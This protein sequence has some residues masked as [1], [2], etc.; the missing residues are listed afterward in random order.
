MTQWSRKSDSV[1]FPVQF[2]A[3]APLYLPEMYPVDILQGTGPN[4]P[5]TELID[6]IRVWALQILH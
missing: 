3:T 6:R 4:E 5:V 2:S 1:E